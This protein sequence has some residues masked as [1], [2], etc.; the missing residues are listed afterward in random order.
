[1]GE[2]S[3]AASAPKGP[4]KAE[5]DLKPKLGVVGEVTVS[6][7]SSSMTFCML[8]ASTLPA[9]NGL[10]FAPNGLV[11]PVPDIVEPCTDGGIFWSRSRTR[12]FEEMQ[13]LI[14]DVVP[15]RGREVPGYLLEKGRRKRN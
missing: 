12:R 15:K 2:A 1:M 11:K 13:K 9:P 3:D 6:L 4:R 8:P 14:D 7:S 5:P 10:E